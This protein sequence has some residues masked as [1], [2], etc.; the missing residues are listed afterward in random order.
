[1]W[2]LGVDFG[3][4]PQSLSTS[5][6]AAESVPET[7]LTDF[8]RLAGQCTPETYMPLP[9]QL[10]GL[11]VHE[12]MSEVSMGARNPNGSSHSQPLMCFFSRASV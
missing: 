10:L 5:F 4:L 8:V 12:A 2:R 7:E 9:P 1:M 3:Y 11:W 6:F